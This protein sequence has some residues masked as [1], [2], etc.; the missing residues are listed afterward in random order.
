MNGFSTTPQPFQSPRNPSFTSIRFPQ[1]RRIRSIHATTRVWEE[2]Q[3]TEILPED[4]SNV[5]KTRSI[6]EIEAVVRQAR[7][8]FGET[9]PADFLSSEEYN[10]YERLY[11][12][13]LR[14]TLPE[15][16]E[17]LREEDPDEDI[18][19]PRN[20]LLRENQEGSL[21]EVEY[22]DDLDLDAEEELETA[23]S[24]LEALRKNEEMA[25]KALYRDIATATSL[26]ALDETD[27]LTEENA[28]ETTEDDG[29][30]QDGVQ[31]DQGEELDDDHGDESTM[32][33]HPLTSAGRF[34]T[35][36]ATLQLDRDTFVGPIASL[37]A[38]SSNKHLSEVALRT[39]GGPRLPNSNATP[40]SKRHHLQQRAIALEASQPEMGEM[41]ANVYLAAIMPGA[42]AAIMSTLVE[43]RKRL[44]SQWLLELMRKP[45]GPR[46]LDA[47]AGGAGVLAWREV[48]R[49]EW[50]SIHHNGVPKDGPAPLG[51]ATVLTGSAELRQRASSLLENTT[52][53]PRL[54]DYLAK[55][56][57]EVSKSESA[58]LRKQYDIIIAPYTLWTLKE[59]YIRKSQ[60]QN[61]WSLLNPNGGVLIIIEKGVPR[62]FELV[63]GA[64]ETLLKNQISSP[65]SERV[66]NELQSPIE[67]RF[68][69][70]EPGMIIAPCTN[71]AQCP[72]YTIPGQSRGRK[73][74]CHF[75][76][77]FIR[78]PYLQRILGAKD[79][80]HEDIRFSY[81]AVQRG[82]DKRQTHAIEQGDAA[83]EAA[84]EGHDPAAFAT[85]DDPDSP[86]LPEPTND[87]SQPLM[88]TLP[89][90]ILPPLKR[91][92][93]IILDLCTPSGT[94]ERW[95][96]PR[97][98]GK[99]AYRDARKSGWGD[100]WALGAK[101]R[102]PRTA[103]VGT[104]KEEKGKKT[105][106]VVNVLEEGVEE[107]V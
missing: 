90:A 33:T 3:A 61:F 35:S 48:L 47:G 12:P 63:A 31:N 8:T 62:G 9:L 106:K 10:V 66:E 69:E 79:R 26:R 102:V 91:R 68:T 58:S 32:R 5:E 101:H 84:F 38:D 6:A 27:S 1:A 96:V 87:P 89:R 2:N 60:V 85:P 67:D 46:V 57:L 70:K 78:P 53:L 50:D 59:D 28:L 71:H 36:P 7:R 72:M 45:G 99:Q 20:T 81:I 76:Q 29:I 107:E 42:Y 103:R 86:P 88:L 18:E 105:R 82:I 94:L 100:L 97:S 73:D 104:A 23:E 11:G 40:S 64:R 74:Y 15:D 98:F 75:S 19:A 17:L 34:D 22:K 25:Q 77:R 49:A 54:P 37:L 43:T 13:P 65:A 24:D 93:H 41:E 52:F 4:G 80:N 16:V 44:G 39:F 51:K 95:T 30:E 92:G 14:E 55:R 56:D 83:T 21:E